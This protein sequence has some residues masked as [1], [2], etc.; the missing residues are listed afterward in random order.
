MKNHRSH[1]NVALCCAH[2]EWQSLN[3]GVAPPPE[4]DGRG[5]PRPSFGDRKR[6]SERRRPLGRSLAMSGGRTTCLS[7]AGRR[8]KRGS[9]GQLAELFGVEAGV[10]VGCTKAIR[11][12]ARE[13]P[14][15][16]VAIDPNADF[17]RQTLHK[18]KRMSPSRLSG[19]NREIDAT[20]TPARG[21]GKHPSFAR[22]VKQLS[23]RRLEIPDTHGPWGLRRGG[24]DLSPV[25]VDVVVVL[26][27]VLNLRHDALVLS[28]VRA[29]CR[30]QVRVRRTRVAS[31]HI[32]V[33][34]RIH[35]RSEREAL[36]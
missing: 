1:P 25:L 22:A 12:R 27:G 24:L 3:L 29:A 19:V 9:R 16:R 21:V 14:Y 10:R 35:T 34:L 5:K 11:V 13:P 32:A 33:G 31:L 23:K 2:G 28:R 26:L 8:K 18:P 17:G 15:R 4:N 6:T 30:A 7:R 20:G 36:K